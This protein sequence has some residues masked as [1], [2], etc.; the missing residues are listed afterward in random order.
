[1]E[2]TFFRTMGSA[3]QAARAR[4][5]VRN[6]AIGAVVVIAVLAAG[7]WW[8]LRKP[9][10]TEGGSDKRLVAQNTPPARPAQSGQPARTGQAGGDAP[11]SAP[12][13]P[14][15]SPP[16]A[17]QHDT[18]VPDQVPA[19]ASEAR[20]R[21]LAALLAEADLKF[22]AKDMLA[23][24]K[25][26]NKVVDQG[27][28]AAENNRVV[29]QLQSLA[30][31]TL[32]NAVHVEN[33]PLT[34]II[35]VGPPGFLDPIA[36]NYKLRYQLLAKIN[37]TTPN[38]IQIG[39]SLKVIHGP[40]HALVRKSDFTMTVYIDLPGGA[41]ESTVPLLVRRFR[42]GL[43]QDNSTP[44]GLWKITNMQEFPPYTHPRT[45]K[46]IGKD[47]PEYPFGK[48]GYWIA[49]QGVDGNAKNAQRY[50][51]HS[52]NDPASIGKMASLGCVRM[53]DDDIKQ[54]WDLLRPES[55]RVTV[56]D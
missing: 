16:P 32:F 46:V 29:Q 25:L 27:L 21:E 19:T 48:L 18:H 1:M 37:N 45:Q 33:D 13:P 28:P 14:L 15:A 44:T 51:I 36:R 22:K 39:Q 8:V 54:V 2:P 56:R 11:S 24:R 30:D 23:A 34:S 35:Q 47:D 38:R 12:A 43:G 9:A 53:L 31:Q 5:R 4:A 20:K 17:S 6:Q 42:V 49:L 52:T 26:Y 50:G 55:S 40:F 41:G 10:G 7:L 3:Q